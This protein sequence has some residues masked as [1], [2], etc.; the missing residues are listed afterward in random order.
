MKR[1]RGGPS[2]RRSIAST[3]GRCWPPNRSGSLQMRV[4]AAARVHHGLDR[5][6]RRREHDRNFDLARPHHR[7]VAGVIADAVLL[8]VGGVVLLIDDDEA[9]IGVGQEQRRARADHHLRL[10]GRDRRPGARA[11]SWRQLGMPFGGPNAEPRGEAIEELRGQRDLRHQDHHLLAAPDRLGHR[12]EIDLGL[13]RPGDA[14]DQGHGEAA[15]ADAGAQRIGRGALRVGELRHGEIRIGL[16]RHRLRRQH[17]RFERAVV[18]QAVDDARRHA[19][20]VGRLALGP[21]QAVG[22]QRQHAAPRGCHSLRGRPG[23]ADADL[24]ARRPEIAHPQAHPQHHAAR[25]QR[26]AGDPVDEAAQLGLERRIVELQLD[27]LHAV[28]QAGR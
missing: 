13:A 4:A 11:L 2:R 3:D 9:K 14:V 10:A 1:P 25:A 21:Q 19:G 6:R 27:V 15:R 17:Q 18:D 5:R 24:F 22:E 20:L 16:P 7:H 8:L 28:V 23:E 12:L 26:V